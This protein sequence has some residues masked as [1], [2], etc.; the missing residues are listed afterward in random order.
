MAIDFNGALTLADYAAISNDPLVKEITKSLHKTWNALKDIPLSTNPSLRQT[1]MRYLNANI[2]TPNWTGLNSEPQTFKSKPKSYE[3]Q[4]YILR[5][6]LTVD[7]RILDQPNAIVDPVESQI[8]MFLEG[9]AYDF[10]DKFINNN[11][12]STAAGNSADC[13]PG[14]NY[15]LNNVSDYDIPSEMVIASASDISTNATGGLFGS[16]TGAGTRSANLFIADL[17]TL[18]DN[19]NAPDGD[20]VV[21][22]MSELTK[23]QIEMA[24]RA[25]GIGA[26]FDITQDSYDRPVEKYK[27]A[28]IRTVGRKSDG[29]TPIISNTQTI[30]GVAATI[31]TVATGS[32]QTSIFA[33]RY[34]SGYVT[35]WQSEPFK[36]KYLGLSPENGIMHNVLFDWGVGLWV[37]HNRALGRIDVVVS[38]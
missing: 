35:G 2:P 3:E 23:R 12:A 14:L 1:G 24:I 31:N 10:N 27:N 5:N 16:G 25:M 22:Y 34:G 15:R 11:P 36:P 30:S 9:F 20:G 8:Q 4:L 33:V 6:K 18:F 26:G 29:V 13:F 37:P 17:Q 7:R 28:T 38:P 19:M 32:R 21:L